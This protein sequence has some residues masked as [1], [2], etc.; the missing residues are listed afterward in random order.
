M[1]YFFHLSL[2]MPNK[3]R[4]EAIYH[5]HNMERLITIKTAGSKH[6]EIVWF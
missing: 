5:V 1:T 3:S 4:S 6:R 2:Q